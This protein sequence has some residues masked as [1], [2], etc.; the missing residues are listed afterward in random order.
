MGMKQFGGIGK[1]SLDAEQYVE[2]G[3]TGGGNR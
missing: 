1:L 3:G 2:S